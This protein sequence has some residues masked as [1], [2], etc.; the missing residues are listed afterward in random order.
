MPEL[1]GATPADVPGLLEVFYTAMDDL[2]ERRHRPA[3]PRNPAV[4]EAYFRH[5]IATDPASSIVADDHGRVV[6][7]GIVMVREGDAFLSFLFVLPAWQ[8]RG[9]GRSILRAC[10]EGAGETLRLST[11]AEADQLVSTGLYA[12]MG[13]APRDPI[14]LL[15]GELTAAALPGL[16]RRCH[17]SPGA[18]PRDVAALD[19]RPAWATGARRTMPSGA[20]GERRGWMLESGGELLGYGYAHP[21]GRIGPVAATRPGPPARRPRPARPRR[22]RHRGPPGG[23]AGRRYGRAPARSWRRGMRLDGTPAVYCARAARAALRPLP[24]HELRAPVSTEARAGP[25]CLTLP[26][27]PSTELGAALEVALAACDDADA[28]AMASFRTAPSRSRPSRM[29]PS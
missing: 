21:S 7:F 15:R 25:R 23:R 28:I 3:Q 2:D 11:C 5:L 17:G 20:A 12:S 27:G 18:M 13:M 14:Y 8:G 16:P 22:A 26:A 29:P 4:L 10:L 9:L 19:L 6:A 24:A 1:R